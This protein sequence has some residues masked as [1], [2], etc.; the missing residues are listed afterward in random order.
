MFY[1][2]FLRQRLER[3]EV[4]L[5]LKWMDKKMVSLQI[6]DFFSPHF[7]LF[8]LWTLTPHLCLYL[9]FWLPDFHPFADFLT[10]FLRRHLSSLQVSS[11][12][13]LSSC[14][15]C[16]L[17]QMFLSSL[18]ICFS[19]LL[20]SVIVASASPTYFPPSA[21][22]SLHSCSVLL[23]LHVFPANMGHSYQH[24]LIV[25]ICCFLTKISKTWQNI[26]IVFFGEHR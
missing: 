22:L 20:K 16:Q 26:S 5:T 6:A 7:I 4:W 1:L 25:L 12:Y 3:L 19:L 13:H 8:E 15:Y 11:F 2:F 14:S 24:S 10:P 18:T 9:L 21:L 23:M 17:P